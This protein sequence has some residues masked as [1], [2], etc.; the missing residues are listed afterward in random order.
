MQE[1]LKDSE[2]AVF[3]Y[4]NG[5]INLYLRRLTAIGFIS[6]IL[7]GNYWVIQSIFGDHIPRIVEQG[8]LLSLLFIG[9]GGIGMLGTHLVERWFRKAN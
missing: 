3:L 9:I 4:Y 8:S 5:K 6:S 1:K 7:L 2:I